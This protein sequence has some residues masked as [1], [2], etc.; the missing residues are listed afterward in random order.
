[1]PIVGIDLGTTNSLI[2]IWEEGAP[3]LIPNAHTNLLTP[4]VVGIDDNGEILVGETAQE[5]L[6]THPH[7]TVSNFKRWMGTARKTTLGDKSFL[8]EELSSLVLRALVRDAEEYTG[9]KITEA[10][11]SVPAYFNDQQRKAT[12]AAGQLAGLTVERI[13]NEPTAAALAYGLEQ[14]DDANILIFDLGGGTFD[15]SILEKF[16]DVMEVHASAG[17]NYLGG[18]DFK[19]RIR[20]HLVGQHQLVDIKDEARLSKLAE[21]IKKELSVKHSFDYKA[22]ISGQSVNGSITREE[23][24]RLVEPLLMRIRQPLERAIRDTDF[25][26]AEID[27]IVLAGG[28]TRMPVIRNLVGT[29]FRQLPLSHLD[30]DHLIALGATIQATLK[31]RNEDLKDVVLTDVCPYTLG[32]GALN[33]VHGFTE[34]AVMSPIIERNATI[35]ISRAQ[36]YSTTSPKQKIVN[37]EVYQGESL[38]LANNIKLGML[39]VKIP[40]PTKEPQHVDVR[41]TYDINGTLEVTAQVWGEDKIQKKVFNASGV[42]LSQ[43]EIEARFKELEELKMP[44]W[45]QGPNRTVLARAERIYEEVSGDARELLLDQ[46]GQFRKAL[47]DQHLRNPE[48]LRK[49]FSDFLD[50]LEVSVFGGE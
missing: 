8:P 19:N 3:K 9:E 28:S 29:L 13:I 23:F 36:T 2:G 11:I 14:N 37:C 25:Q 20:D 10:V 45:K 1:M 18:E 39:E 43:A 21:Q 40:K 32:I 47:E 30:P 50:S 38:N 5:R 6:I 26:V 17:D 22:E 42:N 46:M 31:E 41:F 12:R 7:M 44:P 15:V 4:S 24:E 33:E 35:P 34:E 49:E 16:D 48:R 27:H